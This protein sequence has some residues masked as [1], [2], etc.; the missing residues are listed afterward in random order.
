M[1]ENYAD[2]LDL[3]DIDYGQEEESIIND[4]QD[5]EESYVEESNI[6][7]DDFNLTEELLKLQGITDIN[8]IKFEDESGAIVEKAWESLSNNEK[9]M[10]LSHQEDPDTSLDDAEIELIN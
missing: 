2:N 3:E 6:N 9:L 1:E 10:I 4:S 5:N 8:K 7:N